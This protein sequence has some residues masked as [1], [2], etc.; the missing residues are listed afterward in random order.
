[1]SHQLSLNQ[2]N[3]SFSD[4]GSLYLGRSQVEAF[5]KSSAVSN[6]P[7]VFLVQISIK[8]ISSLDVY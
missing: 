2:K 1:M 5:R 3:Q 6:V 4:R 7:N 8:M